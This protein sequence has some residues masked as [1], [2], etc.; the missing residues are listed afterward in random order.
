MRIK[1]TFT[2]EN[3]VTVTITVETREL[4]PI[5]DRVVAKL[6]RQ[7][8]L[9]GFRQGKAPAAILE[10]NLDQNQLQTEVIEEAIN[11]MYVQ[12][13]NAEGL[14]PV[15]L[16]QISIKK[17]VPFTEL[18]FEAQV[19]VIGEVKLPDYTKMKKTRP[20]VSITAKDIQEVL[21]SL[22]VRAASKQEVERAAK[23]KDEVTIDFAGKDSKGQP[24]Q[25][26]DGKDYPLIL[27]SNTFIPGFEDNLIGAKKGDS[28][29]FTLTF[30]KTYGVKALANKKVTFDVTVKKVEELSEPPL[31]DAFAKKIGPFKNLTELKDDI[32]K[33]LTTERQY[34]AD[35]D[36]ES[37]LVQEIAAKTKM[38][39]PKSLVDEQITRLEQEEKQNLAYRGQTWQEH[40]QAEGVN[41]EEHR[42][43]KRGPA[44]ERVKAGLVLAEIAQKEKLSV[45]PEELE[46]RLQLLKGQ[47]KDPA[48]QAELDK[49][50]NR[51]DIES[52]LL[53]EKTVAKLV[54]Y[55]T[56]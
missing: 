18:E 41:E 48:M 52:R 15:A 34:Q 56:K 46:I 7:V 28:R 36:F 2:T 30:P 29:S 3:E 51:A 50:E 21:D 53:T 12:A 44:T 17:F 54:G 33:Q 5:K 24:V 27:G 9:P 11:T 14:R 42:E 31:D 40:L 49:P 32:K 19:E 20:E 25:G 1:K 37:E 43:S 10:R 39:V 55:T 23:K 22:R 45:T 8:R 13:M 6:G 38:V 26:A 35:R 4:A 47:Y 16:P